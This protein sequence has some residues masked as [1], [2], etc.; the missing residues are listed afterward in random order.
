[1]KAFAFLSVGLLA[2]LVSITPRWK[3]GSERFDIRWGTLV[4]LSPVLLFSASRGYDEGILAVLLGLS[5]FGFYFNEGETPSQQRLHVILMATSV[6]LVLG[7]KGF[8]ASASLA[9]WFL[10]V[11]IGFVWVQLND[12]L[13]KRTMTPFTQRPWMVGVL[14]SLTVYITICLLYTSPSPR[15]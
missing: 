2:M 9:A 14:V 4:L 5:T 6:L 15:D 1:M 10:V 11:A 3:E 12:A 8:A 13:L 7:W